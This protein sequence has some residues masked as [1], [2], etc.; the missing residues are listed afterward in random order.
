VRDFNAQMNATPKMDE[1]SKKY[2][3]L[4]GLQKWMVDA[5]FKFPKLPK[6]VAGIIK[7]AERIAANE[8]KRKSS[9][10]SQQSS[11]NKNAPRG[12]EFKKFGSGQKSKDQS[13]SESSN[14]VIH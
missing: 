7:I 5:L 11:L 3:F 8:P 6:D 14:K 9:N 1:F 12:K 13:R 4:G 10:P 2:I